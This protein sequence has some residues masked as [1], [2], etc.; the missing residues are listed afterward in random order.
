MDVKGGRDSL[1]RYRRREEYGESKHKPFASWLELELE[2]GRTH[3]IRVHL[4]GLGH[5]VLGDPAYG[6]PSERNTKW[7]ALPASVRALVEAMPGQAL[8]A[9][10]LGVRASDHGRTRILRS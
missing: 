3:Q 8:H 9:R 2:T 10:G 1:T 6:T 7:V 5:S 4:T